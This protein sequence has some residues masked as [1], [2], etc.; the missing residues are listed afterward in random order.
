MGRPAAFLAFLGAVAGSLSTACG[1]APGEMGADGAAAAA[2]AAQSAAW[3]I[4]IEVPEGVEPR[5]D[6]VILVT[7]DTLRADHVS[8]YGYQRRTTP[9]LD[10]IAERGALFTRAM[11]AVS[12][13]APSHATMLTG[14]PPALH[15]VLVNGASLDPLAPGLPRMF[16][17]AGYETA[18]FLNV[19]FLNGITEAFGH[20]STN[21]LR[22]REVVDSALRWLRNK[23]T[24]ER[25]F[26]W[27]H[28]YDPHQWQ[29]SIVKPERNRPHV[30]PHPTPDP[31]AFYRYLAELHGLPELP[32]GG[33][34]GGDWTAAMP[35]LEKIEVDSEADYLRFVDAYDTLILYTDR[36]V[37]RLHDAI[38]SL[39]LPGR[40]LWIITADHG[41]GLASH[42]VAGHGNRIY[43]E[44]LWV[45]L[46][47]HASDDSIAPRR[48]DALVHH[49][50]L[51]PTLAQVVGA[52]VDADPTLVEGRSLWPLLEGGESVTWPDRLAFAQRRLMTPE[53]DDQEALFAL[54]DGRYKYL[55]HE[56]GEDEFFDLGADPRELE[57]L[58]GVPSTARDALRSEL[59]RRLALYGAHARA[60]DQTS[61]PEEWL[62]ELEALG[63]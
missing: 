62:R 23:R 41:E 31:A 43:Q 28:L 16:A 59:E 20:S 55:L 10:R 12:H 14:L 38:E 45:P 26:M 7:I 5:F 21:L 37:A 61:V 17:E 54:Q 8:S 49:V 25:F 30:W 34:G 53:D 24:R 58:I 6:R 36:E 48:I 57:N 47:V 2:D 4:A 32:G 56:P 44:Q 39:A 27:V 3:P 9:F 51:L 40:T 18:A 22:G 11:S 19:R 50:D 63:Y 52:R 15:G 13:T 42:G 29:P 1:G 35:G 60:A 46:L 33:N